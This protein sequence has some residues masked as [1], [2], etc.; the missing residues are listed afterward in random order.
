MRLVTGDEMKEIDGLAI[1]TGLP[2]PVLMENAGRQVAAIARKMIAGREGDILILCGTGNN[3]GDGFVAARYLADQGYR[4]K[5]LVLGKKPQSDEAKLHLSL[6]ENLGLDI[7]FV[8][9]KETL[10]QYIEDDY[11]L[12]IDALLGT[13]LQGEIKG[14]PAAGIEFINSCSAPVL[15][16]DIP[17]GI[18]S[19]SGRVL[20]GAVRA[21]HTVTFAWP[22]IGNIV[23]P[24]Y[25]YNGN[26]HV[27]DI[28]IPRQISQKIASYGKTLDFTYIQGLLPKRSPAAHKG[29]CG[30]ILIIGGS[31]G[32]SGAPILAAKAAL[33]SG[34]G[35]VAAGIPAVIADVFATAAI[36]CIYTPLPSDNAGFV[37]Q[38]AL[39][40]LLDMLPRFDAVVLGPGLGRS[41]YIKELIKILVI[42]GSVS[43]LIDADGLNG[44]NPE[45]LRR[46]QANT[47]LTPHYGEMSR[48]MRVPLATIAAAPL[49][50]ARSFAKEYGVT[51]VLKGPRSIIASPGGPFYVNTTGNP[52][53]ATAGSGDVLVG[54][55]AGLVGQM[56]DFFQ[57]CLLATYLHGFAGD[58][59]QK[60]HTIFSM[61][62][63]N[64]IEALPQTF[65]R[66]R[67]DDSSESRK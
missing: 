66:C 64:I 16:V 26:L 46:R 6:I 22:K 59:A 32:M 57:A 52:G 4:I 9:N 10:F 20:G 11:L 44:L 28:G 1:K 39:E 31:S 35:F 2:G 24:G 40:V 61:T 30:K 14:L 53:M 56:E 65:K 67:R 49:D 21:D 29:S 38:G 45:D 19:D 3:G 54:I 51:V 13:G 60:K 34:A 43:L 7:A 58:L 15:S 33:K 5:V 25:F 48:L 18:D 55:M 23:S 36:E 41:R 12:V 63:E 50:A 37:T 17:S 8:E 47:V 42:D 62:A 27:V